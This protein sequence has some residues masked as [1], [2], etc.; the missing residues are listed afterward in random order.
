[1]K[2]APPSAGALRHW[3]CALA[4]ILPVSPAL[5]E[6][7]SVT[8]GLSAHWFNTDRS[9]EGLVLEILSDEAALLYWFTYDEDG[10]QRWLIDVGEI[11]GD[12][13]VFPELTVTRGGRFGPDFDPDDVEYEVVG[14]AVLSF[15]DCDHG[16]FNYSAFDQ[17]GIIPMVRLSQT[18]AAGCQPPQGIPGQPVREYAGQSGSWYDPTHSGEGYT[19]QWMSRDEAVL[20]WFTYDSDGNQRWMLGTGQFDDGK[21]VFPELNTH[22][23]PGF[24][25]AFD[26]AHLKTIEWGQLTLEIDCNAGKANWDSEEPGFGSGQHELERLT[27][28]EQP[29]CPY[30]APSL[31]DLFE[32]EYMKIPLVIPPDDPNE[33]VRDGNVVLT[34]IALDGTVVGFRR[35]SGT[36]AEALRWSPGDTEPEFNPELIRAFEVLIAPDASHVIGTLRKMNSNDPTEMLDIPALWEEGHAQWVQLI[37]EEA[38]PQILTRATSQDGSQLVGDARKQDPG[39]TPGKAWRFSKDDGEMFL[40][41]GE[42]MSSATGYAVSN[43]GSVVVGH[44]ISTESDFREEHATRWVAGGEPEVLQDNDGNLLGWSFTCSRDCSVIA[45]SHH[46]GIVDYTHPHAR[47]PWVWTSG[48]DVTYLGSLPDAMENSH[49]PPYLAFDI[50]TEG[51]LFVGR[52]LGVNHQGFL[53]SKGLIWTQ[54]T[55]LISVSELLDETGYC[56]G[57]WEDMEAISVSPDGRHILITGAYEEPPHRTLGRYARGAILTLSEK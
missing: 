24:G 21:I 33:V 17:S 27:L 6:E 19:L 52:Y 8:A 10:S 31:T 35:I 15:A 25:E 47:E 49:I 44:Q 4:L 32:V 40:P 16:E 43:D 3:L 42:G 5:A 36:Q 20:I 39:F 1:M 2:L 13:I 54:A 34:D 7:F 9:G 53:H 41:T 26:P 37:D 38:S 29:A 11:S 56:D 55:G 51:D 28:L 22:R 46:G 45:G 48:G 14:E 30:Q 23:G 50:T 18:M 12:E 57:N